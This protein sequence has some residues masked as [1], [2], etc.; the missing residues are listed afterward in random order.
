MTLQ[1]NLWRN[2]R[3]PG[4]DKVQ[5]PVFIIAILFSFLAAAL[6][7]GY[8][9]YRYNQKLQEEA[10]WTQQA[11]ESLLILNRFQTSNPDLGNEARLQETN[12]QYAEQ[13]QKSR[14]AYSGLVNQVENAIEGFS[15]PLAQLSN[16]DINGLW[17]STILLRDG[18]RAYMLEGFARNPELIP[19]YLEQLSASS[20]QGL[21]IDNLS[22]I[23]EQDQSSLWRFVMSNDH[24]S[25]EESY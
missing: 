4:Y 1:F 13:L 25:T 3:L 10:F 18:Q 21:A 23:K 16:Y 11:A 20:F 6:W 19:D 9:G 15:Q 24:L 14:E 12:Q 17:L 2:Q 8:Y 5:L 7:L 22:V